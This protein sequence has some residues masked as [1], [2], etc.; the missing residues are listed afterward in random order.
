MKISSLL[1]PAIA[2][3]LLSSCAY[4]TIADASYPPQKIYLPIAVQGTVYTV[5]STPEH[6]SNTPTQGATFLY[7]IDGETFS[8]PLSV[9][10]SGINNDGDVRVNIEF[11]KET[12]DSLIA[13]GELSEVTPLEREQC[14]FPACVTIPDGSESAPFSLSIPLSLIRDA[15]AGSKIAA[16]IGISSPDREV[17]SKY[18]DIAVVIDHCIFEE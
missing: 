4:K 15:A 6:T 18:D 8:V 11:R 10:R 5:D 13:R 1:L 14:S 9:Y 17:N 7:V 16:G 12:L 3:A 2:S